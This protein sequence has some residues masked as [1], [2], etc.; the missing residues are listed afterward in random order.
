MRELSPEQT[1]LVVDM[2]WTMQRFSPQERTF[3]END[4]HVLIDA[5][6]EKMIDVEALVDCRDLIR[7]STFV[8]QLL[9]SNQGSDED[10]E[11]NDDEDAQPEPEDEG[12]DEEDEVDGQEEDEEDNMDHESNIGRFFEAALDNQVQ[13]GQ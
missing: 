5:H 2:L 4:R 13:A 11:V 9:V 10:S 3:G 7:V 8:R 6:G 12:Q 1:Q